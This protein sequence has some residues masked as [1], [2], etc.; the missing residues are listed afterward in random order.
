MTIKVLIVDDQDYIRILLK[1]ILNTKEF[2]VIG[3]ATNGHDAYLL[4]KQHQPDLVLMDIVMPHVSGIDATKKIKKDFPRTKIV[5]CSSLGIES[6][7]N[8]AKNA[9][10]TE[11]IS[12]PFD[13]KSVLN[14]VKKVTSR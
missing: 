7:I 8:E 14:T 9:G 2:E 3:E 4:V 6:V 10:A 12:K 11:F 13:K 5:M 1:E